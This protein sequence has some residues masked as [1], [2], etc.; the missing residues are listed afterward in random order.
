M[1]CPYRKITILTKSDMS[2]VTTEDF[3]EC[4]EEKCAAYE[5]KMVM[6]NVLKRNIAKVACAFAEHGKAPKGDEK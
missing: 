6:S 4:L 3:A 1:K 5:A 2:E